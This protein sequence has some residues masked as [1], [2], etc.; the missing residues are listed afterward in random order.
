[1]AGEHGDQAV[2]VAL[3]PKPRI[4]DQADPADR[5]GDQPACVKLRLVEVEQQAHDDFYTVI[6]NPLLW[7]LQHGMY[8]LAH[9][10]RLTRRE[11]I[12]FEDGY[13]AVNQRFAD[14]V[15]EEVQV[16]GG[17]ALVMLHDYHFYL[18][19]EQVRERCPEAVLSFFLHIPWPGPDAWRI[20]PP[21]WREQLLTGLLGNDVVAF[22]TEGFA[23]N[24]LLCVQ[25]LL[26]LPVDLQAMTIDL[27]DR[28]VAARHYPISIDVEAMRAL[29]AS[30]E[31]A[32][33]AGQLRSAFCGDDRQLILRVDR[34]DPSKNIVRG[35]AAF[36]T[37]LEDHPE[38]VGRV[39]FLAL[40]QPSR[41]DVP[42]YAD[43]LAEIG[44]IVARV[45]AAHA[46]EGDAPI[47]LRLVEDQA[48]AVA[49]YTVCDVLMVNALADGMNLVAK[50]AV[51]VNTRESVLALSENTGAHQ[52]LGPFA[53]TLHPFDIQQ[54]A[55]ALHEALTMGRDLRRARR[56]AAA[57]VVDENDIAKW[58][59]AQLNDLGVH[60]AAE[61]VRP[62]GPA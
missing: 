60:F 26:G 4:L 12:A 34:T 5:P 41:Q 62:P 29:A 28:Q 15:A 36:A 52:E 61:R 10:P 19:A 46:G 56:Q 59:S 47:D 13:R 44:A 48:L 6:A 2:A 39:S 25:E 45:N 27:G 43:Y 14:A 17:R 21:A 1:V 38:L 35:F 20:L 53:V 3:E 24:F 49:A 57:R 7:F 33:H 32:E 16:R 55:D 8:G 51:V 22:H 23:R 31:V 54:Q 11:H 40:L 9:A 18:V 42:E 58:L 50:E 37:L 30:P